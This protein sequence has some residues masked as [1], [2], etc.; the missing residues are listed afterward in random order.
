MV[1]NIPNVSLLSVDALSSGAKAQTGGASLFSDSL[2]NLDNKIKKS[3][4]LKSGYQSGD[5][6]V[7]LVEVMLAS[8]ESNVALST[9]IEIRNKSL[10]AYKEIINMPV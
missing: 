4:E 1:N 6:N 2:K 3:S 9:A 10:E 7:S 5:P 8:Q